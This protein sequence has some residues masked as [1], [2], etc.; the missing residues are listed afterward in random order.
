M[1]LVLAFH[2]KLTLP[3][4]EAESVIIANKMLKK[5]EPKMAR[6]PTNT[7]TWYIIRVLYA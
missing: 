1:G 2:A 6:L 7:S 5:K 3:V 4:A